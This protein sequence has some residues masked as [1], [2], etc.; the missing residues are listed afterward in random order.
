V[1]L[2]QANL[3]TIWRGT[4]VAEGAGLLKQNIGLDKNQ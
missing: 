4:Q 3:P 2:K 1:F